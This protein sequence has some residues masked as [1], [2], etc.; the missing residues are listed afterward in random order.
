MKKSIYE[1]GDK[2]YDYRFGWGVVNSVVQ[3]RFPINV[4]FWVL[5]EDTYTWDGREYEDL[6]PILS[7][8]EYTLEG[9]SQKPIQR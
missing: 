6:P 4:S 1:V 7:F 9:F 2:V 8:T 3:A 5:H